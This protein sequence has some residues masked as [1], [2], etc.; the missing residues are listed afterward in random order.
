MQ[1]VPHWRGEQECKA[2]LLP[3]GNKLLQVAA[4]PPDS[5]EPVAL[6]QAPGR[7][8][9]SLKSMF[10]AIWNPQLPHPL[11]QIC[12]IRMVIPQKHPRI[13]MASDFCQFVELETRR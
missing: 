6:G 11:C 2:C 13:T 8:Q 12:G 10:K 1:L 5:S 7:I 9:R 3:V 4:S